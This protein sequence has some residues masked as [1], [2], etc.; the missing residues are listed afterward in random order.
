V[1]GIDYVLIYGRRAF[2]HSVPRAAGRAG[3]RP[4]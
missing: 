2:S 1:S 4:P 3:D